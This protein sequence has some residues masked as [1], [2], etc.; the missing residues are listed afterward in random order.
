MGLTDLSPDAY[1]EAVGILVAKLDEALE[2][3]KLSRLVSVSHETLGDTLYSYVTL[4]GSN[5]KQEDIHRVLY[6][7][8]GFLN[9]GLGRGGNR[10]TDNRSSFTLKR[11]IA[12]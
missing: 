3:Q 5:P 11:R 4:A 6:F 7:L 12:A 9:I 2:R 8:A 10:Y 1:H